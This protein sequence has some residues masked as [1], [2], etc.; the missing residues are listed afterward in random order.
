MHEDLRWD[1]PVLIVGGGAVGLSASMILARLGIEALLVTYHPDT[2]PQPRA[3]ILNQRTMEIFTELGVADAIYAVSTPSDKMRYA[4]WYS[5][6]AGPDARYGREIGRVEAWG[7]GLQ[8]PDYHLSSPCRPA[9]Y[10]QMYVEP[11]LKARAHALSPG[12]V[13]FNHEYLS[14][15]Q[16]GGHVLATVRNRASGETFRVRARYLLGADGGKRVGAQ[17]GIALEPQGPAM[18]MSSVHFAA[19]LS[20]YA[21]GPDVVTRFMINPDFGGSWASGVLIPEGPT[22]WGHESEEWVFHARYMGS[23]EEPLDRELVLARLHQVL[24]VPGLEPRVIHVTEWKLG[25]FMAQHYR[26]GRVFLMGDACH[27]HPPTGGLGM[28]GGIQDAYNLCWKLAEVL[29]GRAGEALL[30]SYETERRPVARNNMAVALQNSQN[31]FEIDRALGLSDQNSIEENWRRLG[32]VWDLSPDSLGQRL[33]VSQAIA[34]QRVGFRHH[35][36]EVGATYASGALVPDGTPPPPELHPILI[37]Q[38]AARPGHPMP[39]A[40]VERLGE[41]HDLR[42]WVAS[43]RFLLIAGEEGQP[44]LEAARL[45]ARARGIRIEALRIG[46]FKGDW[47]DVRGAWTRQS[48]I[49]PAG[50]VLV[51]PDRYVAFRSPG[52]VDDAMQT[53]GCVLDQI[54]SVGGAMP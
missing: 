11:M 26:N 49:G 36:T 21:R 50:A 19:D 45:Q 13:L 33:A 37:Y 10:P 12:R 48:G 22:R 17:V 43:G 40:F 38:P 34:L 25:N 27:Q 9:N 1:V 35:N 14:M 52:P 6:L 30:D 44:W 31:H 29:A 47:I 8:D 53:L 41:Q 23:D 15:E 42:S 32:I 54:L 28:N 51:R 18:R 20:A 5:G 39:H 24:G 3:H 2:S 7:C 16:E 46:L 4:A